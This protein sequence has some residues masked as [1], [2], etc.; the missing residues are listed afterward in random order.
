MCD[1]DGLTCPRDCFDIGRTFGQ[2]GTSVGAMWASLAADGA[3]DLDDWQRA[4]LEEGWH[5]GRADFEAFTAAPVRDE[6]LPVAG[7][8]IPW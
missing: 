3:A 6:P 5:A 8:E 1:L 2:D 4:N 7:D